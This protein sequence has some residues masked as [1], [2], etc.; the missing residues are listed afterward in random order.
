MANVDAF[1]C[2]SGCSVSLFGD[3]ACATGDIFEQ[4]FHLNALSIVGAQWF[5]EPGMAGGLNAMTG[6]FSNPGPYS[7]KVSS[8][9]CVHCCF[10]PFGNFPIMFI[11]KTA[12]DLD[13]LQVFVY[14]AVLYQIFG[15][16]NG[17]DDCGY[18][19]FA[20]AYKMMI[21]FVTNIQAVDFL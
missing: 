8:F 21:G 4:Q 15:L 5:P 14:V 20:R 13:S 19:A 9:Q 16:T 10:F 3:R 2:I 1:L 7:R 11:R 17:L 6:S 18:M 12:F